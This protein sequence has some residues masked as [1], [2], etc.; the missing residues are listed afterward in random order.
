MNTGVTAADAMSIS[1]VTISSLKSILE[2][3]KIMTKKRVG[4][5][6]IVK[7]DQ[8]EGIITE[9]DLVH[10]LAKGLNPEAT[11]IK[12]VMIKKVHT[13]SPEQDLS[14]AISIMKREKVRRLPVLNNKKLIGMLT[15]NDIIKLQPALFD[16][17]R[18]QSNIR[19]QTKKGK[20]VEGTCEVCENFG[21]LYE[22]DDQYIC[23]ECH[24]EKTIRSSDEE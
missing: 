19:L 14:E 8:L 17:L 22:V 11:K 4:S 24:R 1:P 13:I 16:L 23:A 20:S 12:E 21:K 2:C 5:L 7:E 15:L 6:L 10:F 3:A 9:K 18:E